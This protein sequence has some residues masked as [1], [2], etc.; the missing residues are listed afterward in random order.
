MTPLVIAIVVALVA[1]LDCPHTGLIGI[2][3]N[4]MERLINDVT[5]A[6]Q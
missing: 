4:S 3:Q 6:K 5:D 1:E 2:R